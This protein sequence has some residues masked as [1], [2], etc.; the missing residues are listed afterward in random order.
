MLTPS[1]G[2]GKSFIGALLT[3]ALHDNP[4]SCASPTTHW[5]SSWGTYLLDIGIADSAIVRLGSKSSQ[6][7]EPLSLFQQNS[8]YTKPQADWILLRALE[9]QA[10]DLEDGVSKAFDNYHD[11]S[12]SFN[13]P[14]E[15]LEFDY[16]RRPDGRDVP[17]SLRVS[18]SSVSYRLRI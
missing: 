7:T 17:E 4:E 10:D 15:F 9:S 5:T 13:V 3:K 11:F 1:L 18:Q 16:S 8:S 14:M 2:T 6:R 12:F